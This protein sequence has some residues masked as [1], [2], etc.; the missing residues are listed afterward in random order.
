[1]RTR[2]LIATLL[3]GA[4]A[5]ALGACG[6]DTDQAGTPTTGTT[7]GGTPTQARTNTE[8]LPRPPENTVRVDGLTDGLGGIISQRFAARS[9]VDVAFIRTTDEQAFADLCAGRV[10]VIEVSRDPT[11]AELAACRERGITLSEA[12]E[13]GADAVVL[14]TKNEADVGGDCISV[15]QARDLFRAGSPYASW[16]QLGFRDIPITVTGPED[17]TRVFTF[18]G[19]V[20]LGIND[21]SLADVRADYV[22]EPSER[23]EREEVVGT[24]RVRA[25]NRRIARFRARLRAETQRERQRAVDA[26]VAE[27]DRRVLREIEAENRRRAESGVTLSAE[28]AQRI[29]E[30]NAARV[31]RAK[32]IAAARVNA[33]YDRELDDRVR[34]YARGVLAEAE[35]P[36]VVGA[37]RFTYYELFEEQLRPFEIDL[38]VPV[39]ATGSPVRMSDLT[40]AARRRLRAEVPEGAR[41][42]PP[43]PPGQLPSQTAEGE[44]I[45]SPPNCVFPSQYT[46]TSGAYP[47]SRRLL[48]FTSAQALERDEVLDYV[49]F[50]LDRAQRLAAEQRLVPITNAQRDTGLAI[51]RNGGEAP[52]PAEEEAPEATSTTPTTP[53][54]DE[55]IPGVATG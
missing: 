55:G 37:F 24:D 27:A 10:D 3:V 48:L 13:L 33:R 5:A 32:R 40:P 16:A 39:T 29:D 17:D 43:L 9:G 38:G 15:R 54:E 35:A 45:Y 22:A 51:A 50:A 53:A 30:R 12:M 41:E 36:G 20:V 11:D 47:L 4:G 44:R 6:I 49:E 28:Q 25:A 52:P 14:A 42:L 19:Q 21:P 8:P 31:D 26:A 7:Q 34:R 2:R 18:M 46:I 1:M 23:L